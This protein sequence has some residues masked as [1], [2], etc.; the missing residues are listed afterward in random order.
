MT[1]AHKFSFG[2]VNIQ[3]KWKQKVGSMG[4][5]GVKSFYKIK[6]RPKQNFVPKTTVY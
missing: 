5:E 1:N 3:I 6:E 4:Q 2:F